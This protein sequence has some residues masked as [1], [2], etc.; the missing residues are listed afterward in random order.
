MRIFIGID[1]EP[2]WR[3]ALTAGCDLIREAGGGW[4][5]DKWVPAENLHM[6]LKFMGDVPREVTGHLGPD[7]ASAL[8]GVSAFELP[9]LQTVHPVPERRKA[10]MLWTTF[11]DPDGATEALVSRIE[12]VAADYGVVPESRH[13]NAHITLV[14]TR[15]PRAFTAQAEADSAIRAA[16]GG[17]D[18]MSVGEVTVFSSTIAKS[19][20]YYERLASIRLTD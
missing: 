2:A 7:L 13:F 9:L 14:R 17:L 4:D 15:S 6:T 19:R 20:P 10:T 11:R 16:L 12:D 8:E 3:E 5:R 1:L 18:S